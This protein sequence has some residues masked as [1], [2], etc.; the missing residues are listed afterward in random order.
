MG[1]KV[2]LID[3]AAF[4]RTVLRGFLIENGYVVAGEGTNGMEGLAMYKSQKPD[5]VLLDIAMPEYDGMWALR[6]LIEYDRNAKIIMLSAIAHTQ[7]VVDSLKLGAINFV[8]KPFPTEYLK[9][10]IEDVLSNVQSPLSHTMLE[11]LSSLASLSGEEVL[12]QNAIIKILDEARN[13]KFEPAAPSNDLINMLRAIGA[14]EPAPASSNE[15]NALLR[16]LV[17]GQKKITLLLERLVEAS[18]EH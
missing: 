1:N 15:T 9:T 14:N 6:K 3:D 13:S 5:L 17:D 18:A 8:V 2:L 11:N 4:M 7:A 12:T 16:E 10:V